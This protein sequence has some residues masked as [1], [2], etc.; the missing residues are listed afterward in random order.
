MLVLNHVQYVALRSR[1]RPMFKITYWRFCSFTYKLPTNKT[2]T[3]H[4]LNLSSVYFHSLS[5][6]KCKKMHFCVC[7][8][9]VDFSTFYDHLFCSILDRIQVD[10]K[11]K[12]PSHG[13]IKGF[14]TKSWVNNKQTLIFIIIIHTKYTSGLVF[15]N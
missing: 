6:H 14:S 15:K 4:T 12:P 5:A 2:S 11:F 9:C 13:K 8:K 3:D 1:C 7:V 10:P